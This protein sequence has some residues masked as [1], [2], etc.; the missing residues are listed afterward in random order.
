MN[1]C[2]AQCSN[3]SSYIVCDATGQGIVMCLSPLHRKADRAEVNRLL[4]GN[5][6]GGGGNKSKLYLR[7]N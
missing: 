1:L 6:G 7:R 4:V 3:N 2:N 5:V